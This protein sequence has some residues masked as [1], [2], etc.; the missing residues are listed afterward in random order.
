MHE[1]FVIIHICSQRLGD[2]NSLSLVEGRVTDGQK[3]HVSAGMYSS[4]RAA[5]A[6]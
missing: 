5:S 1:Y 3:C 6:L 4:S 2:Q